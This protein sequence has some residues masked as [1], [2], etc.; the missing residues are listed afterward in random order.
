LIPYIIQGKGA[1]MPF[2]SQAVAK[3]Y[4]IAAIALFVGQTLFGIIIGLQYVMGDFITQFLQFNMARMLHTDLLIL[5]LLF[6][7]MG[8]AYYLVPEEAEKDLYCPKLAL[9]LFWIFLIISILDIL[10]YLLFSYPELVKITGNQLLPTMGREYFEQPTVIKLGIVIVIV[11]FL[12][13]IG[14]TIFKGKKTAI[15]VV[16]LTGFIGLV[17]LF[18]LT[19]YNPDNL[20]L[21]KYYG[22]YVIHLWVEGVWVL[23]MA[24]ILTFIM[25]KLTGIDRDLIEKWLYLIIAIAL[26]SGIIG[27]G[28]HY[29]WIGAP[30]Y[31]Q[32]W[33][34]IPSFIEPVPFFIM[35]V[36]AFNMVN[37]RQYEHPNTLPTLWILGTVVVT[38]VGAGVLGFL[39]ALAPVNYY[40]HG[41]QVTAAHSHLAFYGAYAMTVLTMISYA[42]PILRGRLVNS[43]ASQVWERWSFWLMTV[44]MIF[45]TLF[46]T[47]AGILQVYLQRASET[48]LPFMMVQD[49]IYFFYWLRE[50]AGLIFFL[51][52]MVY[53]ISFFIGGEVEKSV[54][55]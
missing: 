33:G 4:F 41:T 21:E 29:F 40:T 24:A 8:A 12:Y 30:E 55:S 7:F 32:W 25:I 49:K 10:G 3:P 28:H 50:I 54:Q 18:L 42:M 11:G 37:H 9:I 13:N 45:M 53:I 46:L 51:G 39:Q 27:T 14:M 35:T 23:I 2:S 26:M 20:V 38:F 31:W 19:F 22:A 48:P 47:A 1:K 17:L 16:L 15:N 6:G 34:S 44:S 43:H 5:W 36:L 52:L